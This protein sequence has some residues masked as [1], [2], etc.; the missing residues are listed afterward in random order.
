M[1]RAAAAGD[2]DIDCSTSYGHMMV[3]IDVGSSRYALGPIPSIFGDSIRIAPNATCS[4]K[5][6]QTFSTTE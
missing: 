4:N 2:M 1:K 5:I 3:Q 6:G